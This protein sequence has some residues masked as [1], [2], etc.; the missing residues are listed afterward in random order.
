MKSQSDEIHLTFL[1]TVT[2]SNKVKDH[3]VLLFMS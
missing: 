1:V 3:E 2:I